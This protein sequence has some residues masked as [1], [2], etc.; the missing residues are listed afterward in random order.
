MT[1]KDIIAVIVSFNGQEKT[2]STVRALQGKVGHIH[3]VDNGSDP[4]SLVVL[5]A[6][7][8]TPEVSITY[9]DNNRG[10]GHALNLG[11]ARAREGSFA[12]I[13]TMDQDSLV[14]QDMVQA[15]CRI[16]Q[17]HPDRV[18]LAPTLIVH[19]EQSRNHRDG[20]ISYAITSGN[21]VRMDVFEK[22]GDYNEEM[23]I[24]ALDFD[25][26]LRV[27]HAGWEVWRVGNAYLYHE[28]G[29]VHT[30]PKPFSRFY[31]L[32]SPTRRYYIYR[33]FL[34]LMKTHMR[35]FPFFITKS[36]IVH[37]LLL[38]MILVFEE[39][40]SSSFIAIW[41]GVRDFF[42]NKVGARSEAAEKYH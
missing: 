23:F 1:Y 30:V 6:L 16:I 31:T 36:A 29:D 35:N 3:I 28:L 32:H 38:I 14:D 4:K 42:H 17:V 25:F 5:R 7:E 8:T 24:D 15:F 26:C 27:R 37:L 18:C 33:N 19:G 22:S 39:K 40:P 10:V 34:Y 20:P 21:L 41:H 13:L 12:W 11:L 9:L 2:G